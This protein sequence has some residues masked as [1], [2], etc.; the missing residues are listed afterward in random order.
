MDTTVAEE[1]EWT[2]EMLTVAASEKAKIEGASY[3]DKE[4]EVFASCAGGEAVPD[5]EQIHKLESGFILKCLRKNQVGDAKIFQRLNHGR[6]IFDHASDCWFIFSGHSWKRDK[7]GIVFTHVQDV[8]RAYEFQLKRIS[9]EINSSKAKSSETTTKALEGDE[10]A[11]R[12]RI[13]ALQTNRWINDVLKIA[14]FGN[15]LG[16]DGSGWDLDPM[17]FVCQNCVIDLRTGLSRAGKPEDLNKT[18]SPVEWKG[19]DQPAPVW[20]R[21]NSQIF[22]DKQDLVEFVQRLSGYF[23]TGK[24]SEEIFPILLGLGRNGKTKFVE[25]IKGVMGD[26]SGTLEVESLFEQKNFGS[27]GGPRADKMSLIG[28]RFMTCSESDEG[29]KLN[30]GTIKSQTGGDMV[31]A[32]APFARIHT[33]F[34]PTH[35]PALLSNFEPKISSSDP[36]IWERVL[37]IPFSQTF[38]DEPKGQ[39]ERVKDRDL[40][41]KLKAE[42]SGILA[43]LVRGCLEWQRVGLMPPDIVRAA[44][45]A[46]RVKNDQLADFIKTCCKKSGQVQAKIIFDAY[47]LFCSESGVSALSANKF[48]EQMLIK[49]DKYPHKGKQFYTGV[50]L[51]NE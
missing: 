1:K 37:K 45:N 21:F 41:E 14:R 33:E 51:L 31:S 11:L 47:A 19:I 44:T 18:S 34:I 39:G 9:W 40:P 7:T 12:S 46:F 28:K 16:M 15:V 5:D 36:A 24:I 17:L 13:M 30:T 35:K 3:Q 32:R 2:E 29:H 38:V 50:S 25:A 48:S 27:P 20:S 26:Y 6:F 43:W 23:I 4:K 8:V 22:D 42:Y 49:F 10:K